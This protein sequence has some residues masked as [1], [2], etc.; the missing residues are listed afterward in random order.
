MKQSFW[1]TALVSIGALMI[2]AACSNEAAEPFEIDP[3]TDTC[4]NCNMSVA[5]NKHATE[6]ILTNGKTFVFD[7]IGCMFNW[8]DENE[9]KEIEKSFV[10]DYDTDEW[11]EVEDSYFVYDENIKTPM[12]FNVISFEDESSAE[13]FIKESGGELLTYKDLEKHDWV[14]HKE[15]NHHKTDTDSHGDHSEM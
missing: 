5:D 3:E 6:I 13:K 2:M 1:K 14:Q 8:T 12:A 7:D 9:D 11:I 4:A 15:M 10:R